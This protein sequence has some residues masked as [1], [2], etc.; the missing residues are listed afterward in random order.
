MKVELVLSER[1]IEYLKK[2]LGEDRVTL[3]RESEDGYHYVSFEIHSDLDVL[4]ILH[5]GQD[6]GFHLG[7]SPLGSAKW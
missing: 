6:F 2:N 3:L 5:A 7:T 1:K 4:N